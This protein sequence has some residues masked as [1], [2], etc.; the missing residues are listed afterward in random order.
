[1]G[2]YMGEGMSQ[3][4][5]VVHMCKVEQDMKEEVQQFLLKLYLVDHM[6]CRVG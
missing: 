4:V 6:W 2:T 5:W 1:M 3:T